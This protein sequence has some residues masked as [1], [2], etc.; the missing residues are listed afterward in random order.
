MP[1]E[2]YQ[3]SPAKYMAENFYWT[4]VEFE[5]DPVLH[6][7]IATAGQMFL[8][9]SISPAPHPATYVVGR[10]ALYG[11][12]YFNGLSMGRATFSR[13]ARI[14][15]A[16]EQKGGLFIQ[17]IDESELNGRIRGAVASGQQILWDW[18]KAR[19]IIDTPTAKAYVGRSDGLYR[20]KDGIVVGEFSTP[21]VS[22]AMVS[23]DGRPLTGDDPS[24]R[25]YLSA[26]SDA[27]N[28][29]FSMDL[30]IAKPDGMFLD[31]AGQAKAIQSR[32]TAPVIQDPVKFRLW[33]PRQ[34]Q[35][36]LSGYDFAL[37]KTLES[38][39]DTNLLEHNGTPLWMA[40]LDIDQY[41]KPAVVPVVAAAP[42]AVADADPKAP[43]ATTRRT[44]GAP[45]DDVWN[46]L[47]NLSWS[48]GYYRAHQ[49]LRDGSFLV[50]RISDQDKTKAADKVITLTEAEIL[51]NA[52]ANIQVY[53]HDDHM[54]HI[55]ATFT[56][57]PALRELVADLER[58]WGPA[59]QKILAETAD[60][61]ST[62]RWGIGSGKTQLNVVVGET[63]GTLS[64]SYV[65]GGQ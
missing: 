27:R 46:P 2:Q 35:G 9:G 44:S 12:Q 56:R 20:F 49:V 6:S 53:F 64:I 45:L 62:V 17:D 5:T 54:T 30:S 40:V 32:G 47:P 38:K 58:K 48:D 57:P 15:F 3:I 1:D 21:F 24:R 34:L 18:P 29:G 13:G 60:K 42:S 41:G 61:T 36:R 28:S 55:D 63:Q 39:V 33:W 26:V 16:P 14:R 4:A 23:G 52:P 51:F 37:R 31:P 43:G 65:A 11:Y 7:A 50:S 22:F 25:I 59:A 10:D 8:R 19:L